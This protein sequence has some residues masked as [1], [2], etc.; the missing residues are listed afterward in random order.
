MFGGTDVR[1]LGVWAEGVAKD[2]LPGIVVDRIAGGLDAATLV[3]RM[4]AADLAISAAGQ[5]LAE[6]ARCGVPTV[7][8]G[9]AE[10]QQVQRAL[11][12][13]LCGYVDVGAWDDPA[14][15]GRMIAALTTMG[16]RERRAEVAARASAT[17]DGQ[18]VRRLLDRLRHRADQGLG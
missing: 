17:V 7:M 16:D 5:T 15:T 4:Q 9:V 8:V 6:L 13:R 18:G 1:G 14:L 11:W 10:N 3:T 2:V 12:P